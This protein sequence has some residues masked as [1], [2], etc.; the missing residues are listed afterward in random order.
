MRLPALTAYLTLPIALSFGCTPVIPDGTA[1]S[2]ESSNGDSADTPTTDASPD[3]GTSSDDPPD[4]PE[5]TGPS[6]EP[7]ECNPVDSQEPNDDE[8]LAMFLPNINDND[9]SGNS[10]ESI[11]AGEHDVDWFAYM[12]EDVAFAYVDPTGNL[13]ADMD[14]RL[15][16]FV[17][18]LNGP[19]IKPNCDQSIYDET[20]SNSFPGCC[21]TGTNASVAIDLYCNAGD[22]DSAYVFIRIDRGHSDICVP[23]TVGYHF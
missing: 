15:C 17:E 22:D 3:E 19:T 21:N 16:I 12:G 7:L 23:Y 20:P 10:F 11:L 8:D 4:G 1:G 14:L 13:S 9:G 6:E 18:C 2:S 5:S